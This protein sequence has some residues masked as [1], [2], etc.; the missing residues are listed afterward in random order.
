MPDKSLRSG[1]LALNRLAAGRVPDVSHAVV[2]GTE[3]G[4]RIAKRGILHSEIRID[5]APSPLLAD[6]FSDGDLGG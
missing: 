1:G 2:G 5:L 4:V 3:V 6:H